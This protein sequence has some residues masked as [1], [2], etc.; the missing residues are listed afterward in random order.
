MRLRVQRKG[1]LEFCNSFRSLGKVEQ[2]AFAP[3]FACHVLPVATIM[4]FSELGDL[5]KC[6]YANFSCLH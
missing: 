3:R 2:D 1:L 4:C 5:P 6:M